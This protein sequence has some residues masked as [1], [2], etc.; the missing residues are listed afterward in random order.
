M[1]TVMEGLSAKGVREWASH[2]FEERIQVEEL[3]V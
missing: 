1:K 2:V 3:R